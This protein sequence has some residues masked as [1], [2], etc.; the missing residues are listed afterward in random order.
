MAL[1]TSSR[2]LNVEE[3]VIGEM[4]YQGEKKRSSS[5]H[6]LY[7]VFINHRGPDVKET[8]ALQLYN[9]LEMV[10]IRAFLDCKEM[11]LG[12]L[13]PST[14]QD[15]IYSASVQIAIFSRRYAES[16]WCLAE[17]TLMLQTKRKIIPIFYDVPPS[18]LRYVEKGAYAD[19]F[20]YHTQK[21]RYLDKLDSW[22]GAL[23]CVSYISGCEFNPNNDNLETLCKT[24]V[25]TVRREVEKT[26]TLE[27]ARYP[28]GIEELVE[29][30][31]R[32]ACWE[33][34]DE[35][36]RVIGIYG[37][38][39]SG[40]TTLVKELFNQKR[41]EFSGS[42]FLFEVREA[43]CNGKLTSLQRKLLRDLVQENREFDSIPEGWSYLRSRLASNPFVSF[44][45]VIDDIDHLDQLNALLVRDLSRSLIIVTTRDERVLIKAGI[46]SCYKMKEMNVHHSTELF[47]CH[48]FHQPY[49]T[50]GYEDLVESFVKECGGL[51]LSLQVLGGL[52]FG[53]TDKHYWKLALDKVRKTLPQDIMQTLRISFDSLDAEQK[54][55]FMDVAC[56]FVNKSRHMALRIWEASGWRA[57]HT[58]QILIDKC[59]VEVQVGRTYWNGFDSENIHLLRMHNHIQDLGR[60]I[61]AEL[62]SPGR[63]WRWQNLRSQEEKGFENILAGINGRSFRCLNSIFDQHNAL[64][65]RYF[66]GNLNDCEGPTTALLWLELDLSMLEKLDEHENIEGEEV[67]SIMPSSI[68]IPSWIPLQSLHY[69]KISHGCFRSLWQSDR[70]VPS[71]LKELVLEGTNLEEFPKSLGVLSHLENLV[72]AGREEWNGTEWNNSMKIDGTLFT[73]SLRKLTNLESLV[74]RDF[75]LYGELSLETSMESTSLGARIVNLEKLDIRN[76]K[77]ISKVSISGQYLRSLKSIHLMSLES[78][79]QVYL[80]FTATHNYLK[81]GKSNTRVEE[82]PSSARLGLE[83]ITIDGC[84][85]L[86]KI[87]GIEELQGLKYLHLSVGAVAIRGCIQM[88]QRIPSGVTSFVWE[89]KVD[90]GSI[91]LQ[92]KLL[93]SLVGRDGTVTEIRSDPKAELLVAV[94]E[95]TSAIIMFILV[96]SINKEK[97]SRNFLKIPPVDWMVTCIG[98]G[99]YIATVV[100]TE[101][102]KII[103]MRYGISNWI[104][105]VSD[106]AVRKGFIMTIENRGEWKI[107]PLLQHFVLRKIGIKL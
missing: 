13:F 9:S 48:A 76:V 59:L 37:M 103:K 84:S 95:N 57:E 34:M 88:W 6:K 104:P 11:E 81:D 70:Q 25:S 23:R 65:F 2:Q 56:F 93:S 92:L 16:V 85:K 8:L 74:L 86:Q 14:I 5:S 63:L 40:K 27:V 39:G 61:A 71:Q 20:N 36:H 99:K 55:V 46:N 24:V 100:V 32:T 106:G 53:S 12:D 72:L 7:D 47:C 29:E 96:E 22:K 107:L 102:E 73:N 31:E 78:L 67:M 98:R 80:G 79:L 30:F 41:S 19:S 28:I 105:T 87:K 89:S 91:L 4:L 60:E 35:K 97:D 1:S 77:L 82:F 69:L 3:D 68:T 83:R 49:P 45:I 10:G 43:A 54:Q 94:T 51:P 26:R 33:K 17:L 15:A 90:L 42:C 18:H 101:E 66:V 64:Q 75:T 52:V 62:S 50:R 44:L 38:G 58:L 21:R